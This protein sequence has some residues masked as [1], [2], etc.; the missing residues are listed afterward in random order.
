L[1]ISEK[2]AKEYVNQCNWYFL[3]LNIM[4]FKKIEI[5]FSVSDKYKFISGDCGLNVSW[6]EWF[7]Q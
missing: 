3:N 5:S 6:R 2:I 4:T 7:Y 1:F